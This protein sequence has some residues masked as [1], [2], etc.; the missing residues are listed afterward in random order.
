MRGS[1]KDFDT[2]GS[3]RSGVMVRLTGTAQMTNCLRDTGEMASIIVKEAKTGTLSGEEL[4]K[5]PTQTV[6]YFAL[7]LRTPG[8]FSL[9]PVT[10]P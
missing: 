7:L 6:Y 4:F 1:R 8:P 2:E 9:S 10:T 5:A 3:S